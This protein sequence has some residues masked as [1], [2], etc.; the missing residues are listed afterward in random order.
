MVSFLVRLK[1]E[2]CSSI[3]KGTMAQ[4]FSCE[5]SEIFKNTFFYGTPLGDYF[6]FVGVAGESREQ[7]QGRVVYC[8][9]KVGSGL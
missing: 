8:K 5:L 6:L 1:A 2:V 4:V 3:K 9:M 7:R